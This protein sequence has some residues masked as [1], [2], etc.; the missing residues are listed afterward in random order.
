MLFWMGLGTLIVF[1]LVSWLLLFFLPESWGLSFWGMF[2]L[3]DTH[4]YLLPIFLSIGI[5]FGLFVIWMT[6]LDY[7]EESMAKY[8]NLLDNYELNTFYVV[9]LSICAG[10]GEEIFFRGTLQPL[11]GYF[12]TTWISIWITAAF[13]VAIHGYFSIKNKRVNIFAVLLTLFIGLLG[14]A[15][16]EYTLWLAIYAHF[17]YDLVLLF[18][19]K[20][21]K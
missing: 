16:Q 4:Y 8:R 18:Y 19:Y 10:V 1:P 2:S 11:I 20:K 14:W 12:S 21:M 6:E 9:F 17:S 5:L 15:A 7:F 13:F 3:D